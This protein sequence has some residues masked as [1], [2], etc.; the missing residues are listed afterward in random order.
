MSATTSE[1]TSS[2]AAPTSRRSIVALV[3]IGLATAAA[4]GLGGVAAASAQAT[5]TALELPPYAPPA[6]VFGPVWTV[7]Y[8]MIA[9]S[10]W[11]LWRAAQA[12][13]AWWSTAMTWW[14]VQLVLN[15]AWTPIF[16]AG[17]RYGLALAEILVLL[18]AV[19]TTIAVAWRVRR[20]AALLLL[21]YAAWVAFAT[22]LNAGIVV[23][24]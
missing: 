23:L 19:L 3:V 1:R 11:Q 15:A 16:F 9:V 12:R 13:G 6:W 5:Y 14:S 17:D 21:P 10:G 24:N 7:L 18:A 2:A 8:V 22:A 4:A 20:S